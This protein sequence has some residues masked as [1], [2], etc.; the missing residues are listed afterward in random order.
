[1]QLPYPE[2]AYLLGYLLEVNRDANGWQRFMTA[3][4]E[5]F[6]LRSAHLLVMNSQPQTIRFHIATGEQ[7]SENFSAM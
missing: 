6:N 3:V 7:V 4:L 1:M 2:D 5:N